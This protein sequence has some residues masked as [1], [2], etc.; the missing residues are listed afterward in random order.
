MQLAADIRIAVKK[1]RFGFVF[2]KR[3]IVPDGCA[4]WFLP[5]T[6]RAAYVLES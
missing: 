4:S 6:R 3:G 5:A 2:A 1:S